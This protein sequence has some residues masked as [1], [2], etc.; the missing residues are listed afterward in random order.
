MATLILQGPKLD[1]EATR[2]IAAH[3]GGHIETRAQHIRVM[4]DQPILAQSLAD[5]RARFAFDI[6]PLPADFDPAAVRLLLTDMDSTLINIECMDEIA[7]YAGI[8]PQVAEITESAMRGEIDFETSLRRRL[9]LVKGLDASLLEKVYMEKLRLN[10]G[11]AALIAGLRARG[12]K[13]AL[14]SGGFT[15][16]TE[17]LREHLHLDYTLANELDIAGGRLL[18]TVSGGIIGAQAKADFLRKLCD[19]LGISEKAVIASGDGANDLPM[20][21]LAGLGVAYRA[22]P[23]VQAK[24]DIVLN[25]AA[26]DA[27]LDFIES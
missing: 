19:K 25:H 20:M 16:F 24:A 11:A 5:L 13:T 2:Q 14:V 15:F 23:A 3:T 26:L 17:R 27:I 9:A 22:K 21:H 1:G 4:I 10:E 18:G 7:G 8:K 6:N 12:I